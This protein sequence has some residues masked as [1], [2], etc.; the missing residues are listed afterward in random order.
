[1]KLVP[2]AA[3]QHLFELHMARLAR[4]LQPTANSVAPYASLVLASRYAW[5]FQAMDL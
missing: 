5:T 1:L 2:S 4:A 3:L